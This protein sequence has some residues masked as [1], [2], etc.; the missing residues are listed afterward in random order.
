[1]RTL[2]KSNLRYTRAQRYGILIAVLLLFLIEISISYK[3]KNTIS[4]VLDEEIFENESAPGLFEPLN[5]ESKQRNS[6]VRKQGFYVYTESEKPKNN[7]YRR[8][9]PNNFSQKDWE[10]VGFTE[11]QARSIIRYKMSLG[12]S[13]RNIDEIRNCYTISDWKFK[14]IE[15]YIYFEKVNPKSAISKTESTIRLL[16]DG[17]PEVKQEFSDSTK[18]VKSIRIIEE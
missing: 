13:F 15:P 1:M 3:S 17:E 5:E 7:N 9:N 12:G 10:S 16:D 8:F 14:E 4:Q 11:N 2:T 6:E 18:S